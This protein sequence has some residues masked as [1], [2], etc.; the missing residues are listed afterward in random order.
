MTAADPPMS[1][2]NYVFVVVEEMINNEDRLERKDRRAF[3]DKEAAE[4][5]K[6][7]IEAPMRYSWVERLPLE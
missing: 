7:E 1:E 2:Q 6:E 3:H 4:Q 5:F